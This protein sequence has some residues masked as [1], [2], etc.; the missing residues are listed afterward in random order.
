GVGLWAIATAMD[1]LGERANNNL[2]SRTQ[3]FAPPPPLDY[4]RQLSQEQQ[5]LAVRYGAQTTKVREIQEQISQVQEHARSVRSRL[6]QAEVRD[7]LESTERSLQSIETMRRQLTEQFD[8]NLVI[9]KTAEIDLLKESSLRNNL[10]RQ[11]LLFN[12]VVD[13]LKQAK[14]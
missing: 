1:Q 14:F 3:S 2:I 4:L 6:E 10:E 12:T 9:A 5:Q 7:L 8:R 11:R 13:Q